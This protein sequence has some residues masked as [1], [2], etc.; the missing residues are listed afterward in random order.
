M[1][2]TNICLRYSGL[3]KV[4]ANEFIECLERLNAGMNMEIS[5]CM[6][7]KVRAARIEPAS[8]ILI[9]VSGYLLRSPFMKGQLLNSIIKQH[10]TGAAKVRL[11]I[12]EPCG[13]EKT[14][15]GIFQPILPPV[16]ISQFR[17]QSE[18]FTDAAKAVREMI[19]KKYILPKTVTSPVEMEKSSGKTFF[20]G[21]LHIDQVFPIDGT[22]S[23]AFVESVHFKSLVSYLKQDRPVIVVEGP[24]GAGKTT[25]IKKAIEK[26]HSRFNSYIWLD[27]GDEKNLEA[28]SNLHKRQETLIIIDN[29]HRLNYHIKQTV[30]QFLN[31]A[32]NSSVSIKRLLVA[33]IPPSNKKLIST[34]ANR[35]PTIKF[36]SVKSAVIMEMIEK[37]EEMLNVKFK[38]KK[39][40]LT[41]AGGSL[42]VAQYLCH[43]LLKEAG[44]FDRQRHLQSIDTSLSDA[45]KAVKKEGFFKFGD[46]ITAFFRLGGSRD[47]TCIKLLKLLAATENGTINLGNIRSLHRGL[48]IGI[49]SL[50]DEQL[51]TALLSKG[52]SYDQLLY[53]DAEKKNTLLIEDPQLLFF[54]K[55]TE[56]EELATL[57]GKRPLKKRDK[58]FIS[59]SRKDEEYFDRVLSHLKAAFSEDQLDVWSDRETQPGDEWHE[60]ILDA[61]DTT[62]VAILLNSSNFLSSSYVTG[63]ELPMLEKMASTGEGS[64]IMIHLMAVD[65]EKWVQLT[66]FQ[67]LNK[68]EDLVIDMNKSEFEA[69]LKKLVKVIRRCLAR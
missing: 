52:E 47:R 56:E 39:E 55:N 62:K 59:Y 63:T 19:R 58:I 31:S 42:C 23:S 50:L 53:F 10:K 65:L 36:G 14:A 2:R 3:D 48:S 38:K 44:V 29:F 7:E 51:I 69:L 6:E 64:V 18:M 60:A 12:I 11:I 46:F 28:I 21:S 33:G 4:K 30:T 27:A 24:C 66:R 1:A 20:P 26:L 49:G 32:A 25:A 40:I 8:I 16:S 17:N 45:I 15:L 68:P 57:S 37:G 35:V 34:S 5:D 43:F 67:A 13:W 41:I 54:L 9:L 61:I 22:A